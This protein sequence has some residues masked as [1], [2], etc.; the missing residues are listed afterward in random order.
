VETLE[1][2]QQ[3]QRVIEDF[4]SRTLAAIPSDYGRLF[5]IS[6]LRDAD[7]GCYSHEG[8]A[9]IYP[10]GAVQQALEHCHAELFCKVLEMP[11][12]RQEWDLRSC[13]AAL[14]RDLEEIVD[15]WRGKKVYQ[16]MV[17]P[18]Q[19]EYL[20]DLFLSNL[21]VLLEVFAGEEVSLPGAA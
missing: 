1:R 7:T 3:N 16:K 17:P 5:Y 14:D 2:F 19:P 8:L 13:L 6:S 12:E 4:T 21:R 9:E 20:A 11:L 10:S 15:R 18:G